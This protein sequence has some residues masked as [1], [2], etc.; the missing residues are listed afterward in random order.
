MCHFWQKGIP[1]SLKMNKPIKESAEK[2]DSA[3][4]PGD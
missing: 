4:T 3:E 2:K 1:R